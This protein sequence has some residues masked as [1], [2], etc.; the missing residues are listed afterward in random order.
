MFCRLE[1]PWNLNS[2]T[3][4]SNLEISGVEG[5]GDEPIAWAIREI[6]GTAGDIGWEG[7][8]RAWSEECMETWPVDAT[9]C[10]SNLWSLW[11]SISAY[12]CDAFIGVRT[13]WSSRDGKWCVCQ[14]TEPSSSMSWSAPA[15]W[16]TPIMF[17]KLAQE[18]F[19]SFDQTQTQK[20]RIRNRAFLLN[21]RIRYS[22]K[23]GGRWSQK[24]IS[25][26]QVTWTYL[27]MHWAAGVPLQPLRKFSF[28]SKE[29]LWS[30]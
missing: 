21:Q 19:G 4:T 13:C 17:G 14:S 25:N 8:G 11:N 24:R 15:F 6:A 18:S 9:W 22:R 1:D 7:S 10:W 26:Y 20:K 12:L 27:K 29:P 2:Q 5:Q 28:S 16:N 23:T 30:D 3:N